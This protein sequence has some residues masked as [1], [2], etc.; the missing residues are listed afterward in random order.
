MIYIGL[1]GGLGNQLFQI[2]CGI[3]YANENNIEFRIIGIKNDLVSPCD[4]RCLRPTYF[5]NF[6]TN[7][8]QFTCNCINLPQYNERTFTYKKIPFLNKDF[9]INGYFQ[10]PKYFENNYKKIIDLIE[11]DKQKCII[12]NKYNYYLNDK[13]ISI[14]FRFGDF[15]KSPDYHLILNTEY[16]IK[17]LETIIEKDNNCI[18]VLYFNEKQ[19]N[20]LIENII[21]NIKQVYPNLNFINCD[22]NIQDWEQLLLMSLCN[23]NIIANSTFSWW[24]AYFNSNP[25]KIVCYPNIWFGPNCNNSTKDLFPN[26]WL[27][28]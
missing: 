3:S 10:S 7:L 14:H 21:K 20:N 25:K 15:L 28:I 16:Y 18:N 11:L 1:M 12:K 5:N 23:H 6:L 27:N 26:N 2:F 8:K 19:D 24:A 22:Y 9:K 17:S 4:K 13:T